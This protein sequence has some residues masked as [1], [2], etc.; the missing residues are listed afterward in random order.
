MLNNTSRQIGNGTIFYNG[1]AGCFEHNERDELWAFR[2]RRISLNYNPK[3]F[4]NLDKIT[5]ELVI[6]GAFQAVCIIYRN[7]LTEIPIDFN[8]G[9]SSIYNNLE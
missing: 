1:T 2:R 5:I 9:K 7:P 3:T 4:R 8:Y 6:F